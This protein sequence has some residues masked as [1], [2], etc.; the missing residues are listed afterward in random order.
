MRPTATGRILVW[1][2]GSLWIGLAGE[3]AGY[4]A[5]HAVQ[6]ALPFPGGRVRFR[7]PSESWTREY[8]YGPESKIGTFSDALMA[9]AQK[10]GWVVISMKN[11]WK[12]IFAWEQ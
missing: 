10:R 1:R 8:A 2:G 7:P 6:I 11:D 9:E 3:P 4:H 12:R 5:H